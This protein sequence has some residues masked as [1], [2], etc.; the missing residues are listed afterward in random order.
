MADLQI[1]DLIKLKFQKR[2]FT[3]KII[4]QEL[5]YNYAFIHRILALLILERE[6]EFVKEM[7]GQKSFRLREKPV[8]N[9]TY[10]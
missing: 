7:A 6:I 9:V 1:L 2:T 5:F 4:A 10:R 8:C 3:P